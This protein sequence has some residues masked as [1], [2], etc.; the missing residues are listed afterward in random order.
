MG[1]N[2]AQLLRNE[3][4]NVS[5]LTFS[6][7]ILAKSGIKNIIVSGDDYDVPDKVKESGPVGGIIS[8]LAAYPHVKSILI[9]PVDLPLMTAKCLADLRLKGEISQKATFFKDHS[10]PLYLP[11]NAFV[12]QFLSKE[13]SSITKPTSQ[14]S[15]HDKKIKNGPSIKSLLKQV[16]HQ[17]IQSKD[18]NTL[19]NTNTPEQWQQAKKQFNF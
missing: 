6:K 1:N 17:A 7:Q 12:T 10:I 8:V 16:P 11:N 4:N 9:I 2:K 3:S 14:L 13:F 19:I 5:M 15:K 18:L